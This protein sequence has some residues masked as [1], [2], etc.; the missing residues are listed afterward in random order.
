VKLLPKRA[1]VLD[2]GAASGIHVPLFLGIGRDLRYTGIDI[3]RIFLKIAQARYPQLDFAYGDILD[4][5][6]LPKKK[7][8]AFWIAAVLQHVPL[9]EWPTALSNLEKLMRR[10]GIGYVTVPEGRPNLETNEDQRYFELFDDK[11]FRATIALHKWK[12]V[13]SGELR[14]KPGQAIWRWYIVRLP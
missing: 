14:G 4:L 12:V 9:E 3:S 7:F 13:K 2:L 1:R 11:K 5:K 8:D 10:G 6:T